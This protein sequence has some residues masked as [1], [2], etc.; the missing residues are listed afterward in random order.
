MFQRLGIQPQVVR[1]V[2]A[3]DSSDA[4]GDFCR[5]PDRRR[6]SRHGISSAVSPLYAAAIS[7]MNGSSAPVIAVDIP[8]GADADAMQSREGAIA[9]ADAVVTFTAPRPAH[10]FAELTSGP[11]VIAPIG[12][13]QD[14]IHSRLALNL[15]TPA[16][17]PRCLRRGSVRPTKAATDMS[18]LSADRSES[19]ARPRW[20]VSQP[21]AREQ[22]FPQW[23]PRDS[24]FVQRRRIPS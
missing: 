17:L 22:D 6:N 13:P 16:D 18:L 12:S 1:D 5:R 20:R 7:K 11:T 8:S 23:R 9:R 2:G 24:A 19:P 14:A 3:L 4:L 21:Y 15:S 10:V